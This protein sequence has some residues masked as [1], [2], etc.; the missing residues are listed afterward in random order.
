MNRPFQPKP[1]ETH[2][3]GYRFRSR[4]E[5]RWAVFFDA[6]G[7][8]Y[9]YEL[10]GFELAGG[11]YLPDFWF[12]ELRLW[13][14]V[15]PVEASQKENAKICDLVQAT[16]GRCLALVGTPDLKIYPAWQSHPY[17]VTFDS[18]GAAHSEPDSLFMY[19]RYEC[20]ES[21]NSAGLAY[22]EDGTPASDLLD[23]LEHNGGYFVAL[24]WEFPFSD[25]CINKAVLASR[26]ARFEFGKTPLGPIDR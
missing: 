16:K 11:R 25:K 14:E 3:N 5:A 12:P 23:C 7:I 2:Y 9:E 10:E 4:L 20:S 15:K 18:L 19:D 1:I 17:T 6:L 21:G 26:S 13:A 8:K 24:R 22:N